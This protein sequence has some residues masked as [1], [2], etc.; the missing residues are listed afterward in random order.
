MHRESA[1][2]IDRDDRIPI[3]EVIASGSFSGEE[4]SGVV[5]QQIHPADWS[6]AGPNKADH[7]GFLG[8]IGRY[9]GETTGHPPT[10][11]G[12]L[13]Q[14]SLSAPGEQHLPTLPGEGERRRGADSAATAGDDR[15]PGAACALRGILHPVSAATPAAALRAARLHAVLSRHAYCC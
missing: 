11:F 10:P 14:R 3:S 1:G 4:H 8:D 7:G 6:T 15:D 2:Q 5:E 12:D 13:G 9:R